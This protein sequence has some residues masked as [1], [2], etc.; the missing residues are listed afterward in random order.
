MAVA[1][2]G[3]TGA[4]Q[5]GGIT[6][7]VFYYYDTRGNQTIKDAISATYDR[8]VQYSLDD[9]AYEALSGT[10]VRT[11]FWYGSDGQRYK[12]EDGTQRALYLGNVEIVTN[13][14]T[15]TFK[16]TIGGVGK[17]GVRSLFDR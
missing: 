9:K 3:S 17:K 8:T 4:H 10:G 7:S 5:V 14:A 16:R 1:E 6:G 2:P 11:R 12:R 13:G 15:S